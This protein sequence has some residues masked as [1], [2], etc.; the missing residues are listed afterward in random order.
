MDNK[1]TILNELREIS[2]V[3]A[4]I[5]NRVPFSV[6]NGYFETLPAMLMQRIAIEDHN[7]KEPQLTIN[8]AATYQAPEGYFEGLAGSIMNRI[9]ASEAGNPKDELDLISPLL[10]GME[11][12]NPF[13]SPAGF[14]EDFSSKVL[15]G[16]PASEIV[17]EE[18]EN[19]SPIMNGLKDK[20]VYAVPENYFANFAGTV[21][22][23]INTQPAKVVSISF[24]RKIMRYAAAAVIA[25]VLITGAYKFINPTTVSTT[26]VD[27]IANVSENEMEGFLNNNTLPLAD[28]TAAEPA[29]ITE[30]NEKD[31]LADVS[32][33]E[34]QQYLEQHGG[35]V[36]NTYNN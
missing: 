26:S 20:N 23:K 8:K 22:S 3:I 31:L 36:A 35:T 7:L 34:L 21:L 29:P 10:G 12:K 17:N 33:D 11:K 14:F 19:L 15:S 9:K 24:G 13:T 5:G 25:G 16:V 1:T 30:D 6:P 28:T 32:D 4:E 27:G 2:P 18:L